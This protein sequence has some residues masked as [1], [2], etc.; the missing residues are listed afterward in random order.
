M[1]EI[2]VWGVAK[3]VA[4]N[5]FFKTRGYT[6]FARAVLYLVKKYGTTSGEEKIRD[7]ELGEA[8][9]KH[10]E[11]FKSMLGCYFDGSDIAY[12]LYGNSELTE[13]Q[14]KNRKAIKGELNV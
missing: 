14:A 4:H 9:A 5:S 2:D 7:Y 12:L 3:F 13:E 11:N 10:D 8:I 6:D 1:D